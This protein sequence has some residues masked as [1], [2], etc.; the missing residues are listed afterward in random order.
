[1]QEVFNKD[2]HKDFSS[3]LK[4]NQPANKLWEWQ[5]ETL[6][7]NRLLVDVSVW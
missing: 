7:K 4:I 6:N 5:A 2:D 1:M 3:A